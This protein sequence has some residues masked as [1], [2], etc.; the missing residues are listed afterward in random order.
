MNPVNGN[1]ILYDIFDRPLHMQNVMNIHTGMICL[2]IL[3][4]RRHT[5]YGATGNLFPCICAVYSVI[6][7][8]SGF[9]V[10]L[11]NIIGGYNYEYL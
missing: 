8:L 2:D 10:D 4:H 9:M 7:I 5:I 6:A 11:K 3:K 1:I